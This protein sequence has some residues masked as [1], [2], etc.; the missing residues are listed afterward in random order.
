MAETI[1]IGVAW[2]YANSPLHQGQ[3]VG[4]FLPAD[5]LARYHRQRG[6][7]VLMVSGSDQH[8]T[9]ITVRAEQ[10]G[11]TPEEIVKEF[12][13]SFL[14]SL[15][16]LGIS[17][18]LFTTTGTQNHR[19]TVQAIFGKLLEQGDIYKETMTLLYCPH[20]ERFLPDRYVEGTCPHCSYEHARGDECESC[21]RA[22]DAMDLV[23]PRCKLCGATPEPRESEHHF[24][25]L[26]GYSD[27]LRTWISERND[28]RKHVVNFSLGV[29]NEGLRDRAITRDLDWGIPL[30]N[31]ELD[32]P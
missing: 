17:M 31:E 1:L 14:Q 20:E 21:S 22:L 25:R 3:I 12:H 4:S 16:W 18:D 28:W 9:P 24:L 2:P 29:L 30:P 11:R 10:E 32:A 27:R 19:E 23:E 26:T 7:R 15:D 5:C 8:G 13:Q 6:D